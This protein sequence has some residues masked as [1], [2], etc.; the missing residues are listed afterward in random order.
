MKKNYL[1]RLPFVKLIFCLFLLQALVAC[2]KG[3]GVDPGNG[4]IV[5]DYSE[6][7]MKT[8]IVTYSANDSSI[9]AGLMKSNNLSTSGL[10][11]YMYQ[12]YNALDQTNQMGFYQIAEAEQVQNGLP[13]FFQDLMFGFENGKLNGPPPAAQYIVGNIALDNQPKLALST[14]RNTFIKTDDTQEGHNISIQ[15]STLVAQLGYYN[16]SSSATT[17]GGVPNYIK[18]WYVHPRYT[19]F[20]QGYFRDDNGGVISFS[21]LI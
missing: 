13:V 8:F 19:P 5:R 7:G 2:K 15:D 4:K 10:V 14:L 16:L 20:P 3:Q 17:E 9:V 21:P 1:I 11:F 12:A 18:A 6:V